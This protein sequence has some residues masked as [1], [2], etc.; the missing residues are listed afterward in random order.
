M[1]R[2]TVA[3][4]RRVRLGWPCLLYEGDA[5]TALGVGKSMREKSNPPAC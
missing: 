5:L 2:H 4:V 3:C 1:M